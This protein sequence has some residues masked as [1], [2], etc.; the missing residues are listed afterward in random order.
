MVEY[1]LKNGQKIFYNDGDTCKV[2]DFCIYEKGEGKYI[3]KKL[4]SINDG[5]Y[6][7]EGNPSGYKSTDSR[8]YGCLTKD[9]FNTI[10]VVKPNFDKKALI[11]FLGGMF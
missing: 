4:I 3:V 2:G 1:G 9:E 6:W 8:S 5:C 11:A 10:G 7:F